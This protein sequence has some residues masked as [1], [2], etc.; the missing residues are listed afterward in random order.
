MSSQPLSSRELYFRLLSYVRPYWKIFVLAMVCMAASAATEPLFPALMGQL[1]DV[2]FGAGKAKAG[3]ESQAGE[4]LGRLLDGTNPYVFPVLIIAIFLTRSI[5]GFIADYL[6]SWVSNR[7][8]TNL[9][10]AMFD[11]MVT[12]PTTYFDNQSTGALISKIAYDVSGVTAAATNVV[13]VMVKDSMA[14]IGLLVWLMWLNWSLT[15]IVLVMIP[16]IGLA[17]RVFS[18]RLRDV[19]RGAQKSFGFITHVLEESIAAHKVVKIFGGQDYERRRFH[20]ANNR[21][22]GFN[23]RYTVAAGTQGPMVQFAAAVVLAIIV[24]ITLHQSAT[25]KATVDRKSV[26]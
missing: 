18:R 3:A 9:R 4:F 11:R 8:V 6:F 17:V 24:T 16:V 21:Q 15:L 7:V 5:L 26:V 22:R 2:G 14:V 13:T 23:M 20:E 10:D 25:D 12:L 1:L 19:S